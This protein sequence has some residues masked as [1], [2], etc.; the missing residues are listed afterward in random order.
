[1]SVE[2]TR[3]ITTIQLRCSYV[4]TWK[5]EVALHIGPG[6]TFWRTNV[7][8]RVVL[9]TGHHQ[10]Q[11]VHQVDHGEYTMVSLFPATPVVVGLP[12]LAAF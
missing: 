3:K 6:G 9:G 8:E 1:L 4:M 12:M 10:V 7:L 5:T 11:Q 2:D